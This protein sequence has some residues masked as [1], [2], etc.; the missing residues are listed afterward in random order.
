MQ[1][2]VGQVAKYNMEWNPHITAFI[3]FSLA[4]LSGETEEAESLS[5]SVR[6]GGHV[7]EGEGL[8]GMEWKVESQKDRGREE[9]AMNRRSNGANQ[10]AGEPS[11][12][13][14]LPFMRGERR[15][16][17]RYPHPQLLLP[18]GP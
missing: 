4:W 7:W 17:G 14:P 1:Q 8:E 5:S 11:R 10:R 6:I 13:L 2:K 12:D 3:H 16:F 9:G 18:R 15:C